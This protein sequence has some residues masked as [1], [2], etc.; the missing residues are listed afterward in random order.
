MTVSLGSPS[1]DCTRLGCGYRV[2]EQGCGSCFCADPAEMA[3]L[4]PGDRDAEAEACLERQKLDREPQ[5][6]LRH[7]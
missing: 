4:F 1:P 3:R 6:P 7:S 5:Y 2:D